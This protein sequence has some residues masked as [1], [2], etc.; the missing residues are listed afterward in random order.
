MDNILKKMLAVEAEAEKIVLNATQEAEKIREQG[1]L[2][3]NEWSNKKQNQLAEE[4]ET[5]LRQQLNQAE[6]QRQTQLA[7]AE[8]DLRQ[9]QQEFQAQIARRLPALRQA[10]LGVES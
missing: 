5:F 7:A 8:Q 3:A 6:K 9:R 2:Q 4:V 1:R 10:L